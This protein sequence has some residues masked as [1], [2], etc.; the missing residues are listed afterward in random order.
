MVV[1]LTQ[2]SKAWAV[3]SDNPSVAPASPVP[4]YDV[5]VTTKLAA[6]GSAVQLDEATTMISMMEDSGTAFVW[7]IVPTSGAALPADS[8]ECNYVTAGE[9]WGVGK[10]TGAARWFKTAAAS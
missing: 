5:T 6:I 3:H 2:I 8:P 9:F 1:K 10:A 7:A 4:Y